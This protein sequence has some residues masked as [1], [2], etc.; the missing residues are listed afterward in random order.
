MQKSA[1]AR[2][3]VEV[4]RERSANTYALAAT[5]MQGFS[6]A[7][8]PENE[9]CAWFAEFSIRLGCRARRLRPTTVASDRPVFRL[10]Q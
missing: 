10:V 1:L 3:G 4:Q 5:M 7:L 6:D 8:G 9:D 2:T